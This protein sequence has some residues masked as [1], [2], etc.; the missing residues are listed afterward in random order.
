M[1][2]LPPATWSSYR[3]VPPLTVESVPL[4]TGLHSLSTLY[5][6][7]VWDEMY[8]PCAPP[9]PPSFSLPPSL[10][11]FSPLECTRQTRGALRSAQ[12][13]EALAT[14]QEQAP[15]NQ[16]EACPT[17]CSAVARLLFSWYSVVIYIQSK[18]GWDVMWVSKCRTEDTPLTVL[19]HMT[20]LH[21][22][23]VQLV[24]MK[25]GDNFR[26]LEVKRPRKKFQ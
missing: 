12:W 23:V 16:T 5:A 25:S 21:H 22:A 13:R 4:N 6:C 15:A 24:Q 7:Y 9:L 17:L 3:S 10:A 26:T 18:T 2:S 11:C 20:Q 14:G 19:R 8:P 1:T